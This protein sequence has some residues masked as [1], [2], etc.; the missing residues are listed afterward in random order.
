MKNKLVL[1]LL[2]VASVLAV[3]ACDKATIKYGKQML[4]LEG[5]NSENVEGKLMSAG[6]Y[7]EEGKGYNIVFLS[8]KNAP[9]DEIKEEPKG[10]WFSIDLPEGKTNGTYDLKESLS[11]PGWSFY[12]Y[13]DGDHYFDDGRFLDGTL[14]IALNEKSGTIDFKIDA[15]YEDNSRIHARYKGK[16]AKVDTY[17]NEW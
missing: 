7:H 9:S 3:V 8:D 12:I 1:I 14:K 17:I 16:I 11:V 5:E 15:T 13:A 2:V 6:Y 10:A 4:L